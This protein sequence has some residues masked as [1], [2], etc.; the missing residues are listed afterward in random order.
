MDLADGVHGNRKIFY[1]RHSNARIL[2]FD[3]VFLVESKKVFYARVIV[4]LVQLL[5]FF[6]LY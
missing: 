3:R 5:T 1:L 6:A 4:I 2:N